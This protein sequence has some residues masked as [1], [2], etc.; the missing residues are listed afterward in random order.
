MMPECESEVM[1]LLDLGGDHR[2]PPGRQ[3]GGRQRP[4]QRG[5]LGASARRPERA[6]A[7]GGEPA[8]WIVPSAEGR[9]A[10]LDAVWSACAPRA[11]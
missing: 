8:G 3:R 2:P 9:G 11:R 10:S 7:C 6:V 5:G 1:V 4:D